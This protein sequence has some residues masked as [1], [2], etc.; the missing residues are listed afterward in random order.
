[1]FRTALCDFVAAVRPDRIYNP[2]VGGVVW[3]MKE[4]VRKKM[5]R[6]EGLEP[7]TLGFGIRCSTN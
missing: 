3:L 7:P 4:V 6:P 5:A 1:M 2:R